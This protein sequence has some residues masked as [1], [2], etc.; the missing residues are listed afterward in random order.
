MYIHTSKNLTELLIPE[1]TKEVYCFN[2][3]LT[4]L[5]LPDTLER[6]SCRN[7]QLSELILPDTLKTLYCDYSVK[8]INLKD[9]MIINIYY[10]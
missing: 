1:G 6:L 2:N 8:L 7:N 4:E 3:Q 9:H 10:Y 5:T